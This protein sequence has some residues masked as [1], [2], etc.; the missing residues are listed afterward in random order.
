SPPL[1]YIGPLA[2][3]TGDGDGRGGALGPSGI[4]RRI[5]RRPGAGAEAGAVEGDAAERV[6]HLP[7]P[8]REVAPRIGWLS[9]DAEIY[10]ASCPTFIC[11]RRGEG[12]GVEEREDDAVGGSVITTPCAIAITGL[13]RELH[14]G[15]SRG[16]RRPHDRGKNGKLGANSDIFMVVQEGSGSTGRNLVVRKC[17]SLSLKWGG[18]N[19]KPMEDDIITHKPT[20]NN[21][22][23][24]FS[25]MFISF[26]SVAVRNSIV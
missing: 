3:D 26:A 19:P 11:W 9:L 20:A 5:G 18:W 1:P 15:R 16:R 4:G 7:R 10:V 22:T 6:R 12:E 21:T 23:I 8:H 24:V 17:V 2:E 13:K 14:Q 25:S